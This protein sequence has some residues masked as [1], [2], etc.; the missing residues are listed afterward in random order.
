MRWNLETTGR[1]DK[2]NHNP[3]VQQNFNAAFENE[4]C[5]LLSERTGLI[6]GQ[7]YMSVI[8]FHKVSLAHHRLHQNLPS[9][10]FFLLASRQR[11][12]WMIFK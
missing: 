8:N 2:R 5:F 3:I 1:I 6:S 9:N 10:A 7:S 4:S 12:G 11:S